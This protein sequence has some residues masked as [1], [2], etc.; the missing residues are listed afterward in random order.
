MMGT[1]LEFIGRKFFEQNKQHTI[2][3]R[4]GFEAESGRCGKNST[5]KTRKLSTATHVH[6]GDSKL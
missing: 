3:A 5:T 1:Q 2:R 4:G 6:R